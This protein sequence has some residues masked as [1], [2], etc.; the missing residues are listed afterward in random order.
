[1]SQYPALPRS[2]YAKVTKSIGTVPSSNNEND[3]NATIKSLIL[4]HVSKAQ[5][6]S[7]NLNGHRG[8][9]RDV[10]G[11]VGNMTLANK[12]LVTKLKAAPPQHSIATIV[13]S[14]S[15]VSVPP[16][17]PPPTTLWA[18]VVTDQ[19][20]EIILEDDED[21]TT[22]DVPAEFDCDSAD[23]YNI[24][25]ASEYVVDICTY[26]RELEQLTP[27]RANFLLHRC[28]GRDHDRCDDSEGVRSFLGTASPHNRAVLIDWLYQVH[29][30]FKLLS[31]T[32]HMTIQ[33]ID[34]YLQVVDVSKHE[35]QLIGSTGT[36]AAE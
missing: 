4:K 7:L 5:Q 13:E 30:R 9:M 34:R 17:A 11:E 12:P 1:M 6:A 29:D 31:D 16:P 14:Q 2:Y 10:L 28:E 19:V 3:E 32:F 8:T 27:I 33:L 35:L 22:T 15:V 23:V 21:E 25:T 18:T 20:E 36:N 26:W 24:T